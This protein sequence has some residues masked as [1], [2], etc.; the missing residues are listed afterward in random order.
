MLLLECFNSG[1]KSLFRLCLLGRKL[2][3]GIELCYF[4]LQSRNFKVLD[5]RLLL[6]VT[7]SSRRICF[8]LEVTQLFDERFFLIQLWCRGSTLDTWLS[9]CA[10]NLCRTTRHR[11]GEEPLLTCFVFID[12]CLASGD[13][14]TK[15]FHVLVKIFL[16]LR[17]GV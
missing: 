7:L 4:F 10:A 11:S 14:S 5:L 16:G 12:H 8:D 6:Q 15:L 2:F 1:L 3:L 13:L 17:C 9:N